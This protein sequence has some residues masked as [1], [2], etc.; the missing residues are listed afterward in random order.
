MASIRSAPRRQISSR[1]RTNS[2]RAS[3][4]AA[5]L[6]IGVPPFAG[7]TTPVSPIND[8]PE[9][10]PR[11]SP[12]PASTTFVHTS[13]P[14]RPV[15]RSAPPPALAPSASRQAIK[16]EKKPNGVNKVIP[17]ER[18]WLTRERSTS[19]KGEQRV[20]DLGQRLKRAAELLP[21]PPDQFERLL[22]RART[23][24]R[25]ALARL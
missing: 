12:G 16:H 14:A 22:R 3:S 1:A 13:T 23:R 5:T 2:W 8:R 10:T 19:P 25:G 21:I 20:G 7:V 6:S 4:V 24:R 9:G 11:P 18:S 15:P 17:T